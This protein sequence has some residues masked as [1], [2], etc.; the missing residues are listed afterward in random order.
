M[1]FLTGD[2][3]LIAGVVI[4]IASYVVFAFGKFPG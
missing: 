2:V 3:R 1:H 4:F